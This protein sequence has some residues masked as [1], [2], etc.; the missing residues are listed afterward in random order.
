MATKIKTSRIVN[1]KNI[2]EFNADLNGYTAYVIGGNT[3]GK[4]TFINFLVDRLNGITNDASVL[5]DKTKDGLAEMVLSDGNSFKYIITPEGKEKLIFKL[6]DGIEVKA[7][8]EIISRYIS[9]P[10]DIDRFLNSTPKEKVG[11]LLKAFNIDITNDKEELSQAVQ[12]RRVWLNIM[13]EREAIFK[14]TEKVE[15][16]PIDI[17]ELYKK[18][19]T[20]LKEHNKKVKEIEDIN[21]KKRQEYEEQ[22]KVLFNKMLEHNNKIAQAKEEKEELISISERLNKYPQLLHIKEQLDVYINSIVVGKEKTVEELKQYMGKLEL[23]ELPK[24]PDTS[25]IDKEIEEAQR[26]NAKL[27][28]NTEYEMIKKDYEQAV[29]TYNEY[30]ELVKS[31][32]NKINAKLKTIPLPKGL[33]INEDNIYY[34]DFPVDEQHLS[35]SELYIV[36]L[37]IGSLTLKELKMLHFDCSPLDK[38]SMATVF[39]FAKANDLQLLI[40]KPDFDGGELYYEIVEE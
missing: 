18:K 10:F 14:N 15:G 21:N 9:K 19:E 40:E 30:D 12:N 5:K 4:T 20:I 33:A 26:F 39:E 6:K 1:I 24:T 25:S 29:N 28:N 13:K 8:K 38:N 2:S 36:S 11:L 17:D 37:L 31:I 35:K 34:N 22:Y 27:A 32:E 16:E 23:L 7:T 3:K